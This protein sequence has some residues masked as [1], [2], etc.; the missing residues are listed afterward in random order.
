MRERVRVY[1]PDFI[2]RYFFKKIR[3]NPGSFR[4]VEKAIDS[5]RFPLTVQRLYAIALFY[6]FIT[7][8]GAI[9]FGFLIFNAFIP[10]LDLINWI[11][12]LVGLDYGL[13]SN[14]TLNYLFLFIW[15]SIFGIIAYSLVNNLVL[16]YPSIVAKRRKSEIDTYLPHSINMMLCMS[17]GGISTYEI[18]KSLAESND[19][20]GELS[21]EFATM[22]KMSEFFE[23]DLITSIQY[24]RDTTP[25]DKLSFFLEDFIFMIKGGGNISAF[26]ESKSKEYIERQEV[27][28]SSYLD[29][30]SVMAEVYVAAFILLPLF[31]L[32]MLVVMQISGEIMLESYKIMILTI[33]PVS[34]IAFIFIIKSAMPIP[35]IKA[36]LDGILGKDELGA[37]VEKRE[38][39][40]KINNVER[41]LRRIK[42]YLL[43]PFSKWAIYTAQLRFFVFYICVF[44]LLVF[45]ISSKFMGF[46]KVI[47]VTVSAFIIPLLALIEIRGRII[48]Q[49]EK[50]I[51]DMF[52]ELAILN[53]AGLNIIEALKVLTSVEFGIMSREISLLRGDIEWGDPVTRAFRKMEMR[54]KSDIISKVIPVSVRAIEAS[55]SFKDAF[56]TVSSFANSEIRFKDKIRSNMFTYLV[57]IYFSFMIFLVIVY[58]LINNVLYGFGEATSITNI[59]QIKDTS[60]QISI[61]IGLFSGLVAGVISSGKITAGFKHSYVFLMVAYLVFTYLIA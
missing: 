52:R 30:L 9:I 58:V 34:T 35:Q 61:A 27:E 50:R 46:Q 11:F 51:P 10:E 43:L 39:D 44:A 40:F 7:S 12:G 57:I 33:L 29:F 47:I 1:V 25:S 38:S 3:E 41:W 26:L 20:F 60:L 24:V 18:I 21:K 56:L 42:Y 23:E 6:S 37:S 15:I 49:I 14:T 28:F 53:E 22:I 55:P 2:V 5:A 54:I 36:E 8:I 48:G 17:S 4:V 19:M 31:M 16:S 45:A 32:I 59:D 13:K